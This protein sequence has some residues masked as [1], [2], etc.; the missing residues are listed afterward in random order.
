MKCFISLYLQQLAIELLVV[1]HRLLLT[2]EETDTQRDIFE[3]IVKCTLAF[4]EKLL[5]EEKERDS[6]TTTA[7]LTASEDGKT[8]VPVDGGKK[9]F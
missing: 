7:G 9:Y 5:K 6:T 8:D 4:Q 1:S 3:I 2:S